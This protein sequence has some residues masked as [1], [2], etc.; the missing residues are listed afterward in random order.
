MGVKKVGLKTRGMLTPH[1]VLFHAVANIFH[2]SRDFLC[3]CFFFLEERGNTS[4]FFQQR[5]NT[6]LLVNLENNDISNFV[7]INKTFY[8][9][10]FVGYS[11]FSISKLITINSVQIKFWR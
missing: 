11:V 10:T 7:F 4:F 1:H 3:R 8:I 6:S 9:C 2:H 5:G